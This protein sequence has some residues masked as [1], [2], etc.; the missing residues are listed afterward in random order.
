MTNIYNWRCRLPA[1]DI[2]VANFKGDLG[3]NF[4]SFIDRALE[5]AESRTPNRLHFGPLLNRALAQIDVNVKFAEGLSSSFSVKNGHV[6]V[7]VDGAAWY[8]LFKKCFADL[9]SYIPLLK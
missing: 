7:C 8:I 3:F 1:W 2:L 5:V 6:Y 9:V 4:V